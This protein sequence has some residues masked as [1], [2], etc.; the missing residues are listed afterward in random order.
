MKTTK[1]KGLILTLF[2]ITGLSALNLEHHMF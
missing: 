1:R 2:F